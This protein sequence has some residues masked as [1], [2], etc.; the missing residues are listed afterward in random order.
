MRAMIFSAALIDRV[1]E[2]NDALVFLKRLNQYV[3]KS[4]AQ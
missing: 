3:E 2:C 4:D 1:V